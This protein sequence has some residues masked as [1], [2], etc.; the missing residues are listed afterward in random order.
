MEERALSPWE[1]VPGLRVP[2]AYGPFSRVAALATRLAGWR[3]K[4]AQPMPEKCVNVN[5]ILAP[6]G[7]VAADLATISGYY[8]SLGNTGAKPDLACRGCFDNAISSSSFFVETPF[9][10]G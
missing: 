10:L 2:G 6:S 4:V 1:V 3:I 8:R 5:A 7:D 9:H